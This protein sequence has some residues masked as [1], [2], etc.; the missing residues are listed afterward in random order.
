MM[1][2][3]SNKKNNCIFR[4][5]VLIS[6]K[7]FEMKKK[8]NTIVQNNKFAITKLLTKIGRKKNGDLHKF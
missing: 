2:M 5:L 8:N 6:E 3:I 1:Y 7:N 4:S